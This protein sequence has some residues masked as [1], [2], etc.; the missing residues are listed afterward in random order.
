M[1]ERTLGPFRLM[2]GITPGNA[3]TY[4]TAAFLAIPMMAS[5]S[6]LQPIM[7]KVVDVDRAIQGTLSGDLT[8]YQ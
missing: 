6:F 5:L 2:P 4:F 7:L 3:L 1:I 8:F